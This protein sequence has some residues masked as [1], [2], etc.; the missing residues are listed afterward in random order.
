MLIA[1]AVIGLGARLVHRPHHWRSRLAEAIAVVAVGL[2]TGAIGI[3]LNVAGLAGDHATTVATGAC[4]VLGVLSSRRSQFAGTLIFVIATQV[5]VAS[6]IG[7]L[8]LEDSLIA[9]LLFIVS[10]AVLIAAGVSRIGFALSARVVGTVSYVLGTFT[11]G[12]MQDNVSTSIGALIIAVVLFA[13][14]TRLLQ[15]EVIAGGAIAV[16]LTTSILVS[17]IIDDQVIQG[18]AIVIIGIAM[19]VAAGAVNKKRRSS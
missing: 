6:L 10:G 18:L 16:T 19:V 1:G 8:N 5:F 9:A 17:R 11:F 13:M 3:F 15:L 14:S 4:V 2:I 12:V 7:T